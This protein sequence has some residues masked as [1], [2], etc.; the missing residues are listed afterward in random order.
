MFLGNQGDTKRCA[1]VWSRVVQICGVIPCLSCQLLATPQGACSAQKRPAKDAPKIASLLSNPRGRTWTTRDEFFAPFAVVKQYHVAGNQWLTPL[2]SQHNDDMD[3]APKMT[4]FRTL[5]IFR[6]FG[7]CNK[8]L[9][10]N[11][12]TNKQGSN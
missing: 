2:E 8:S 7:M 5:K 12:P 3:F 10:T 4:F 11:K 6:E 1:R 9:V